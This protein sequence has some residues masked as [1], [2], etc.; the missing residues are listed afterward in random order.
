MF[1]GQ[2]RSALAA[3]AA[4]ALA[5]LA[6]AA[7]AD[8]APDV[9]LGNDVLPTFQSVRLHLDADRKDY[10]GAI[11]ADL[12]VV[13]AT[14]VVRLHALGQ[15]LQRVSLRQGADTV[16][17]TIE[18]G[19]R[20]LLTLT[21]ATPLAPGQASL[22]IEFTADFGTRAVGLYRVTQGGRGYAFTQ[23]ESDDAR[24]AF[25]CWD[26][27]C[28]K[29]PYQ[30]TLEVPEAHEAIS[31]TPVASQS[32][33]AGWKTVMFEKTPPLPSYLLAVAT[34][35]LEFVP[36]PGM[37]FPTR[38]VTVRGQGH[39]AGTTVA[40]VPRIVAG[41]EKWFGMPYP[42]AK[43]DLIAVPD[44]AYGAMENPGAITFRDDGLLLD[45]AT[46][47]ASCTR[48]ASETAPSAREHDRAC[49][50]QLHRVGA[51]DGHD[52]SLDLGAVE[53][54]GRRRRVEALAAEAHP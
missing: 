19:E 20:G 44:F 11:H 1:R 49:R 37:R 48:P 6:P 9:R 39:L 13:H 28:F 27:P 16:H 32:V 29:F 43:L 40:M 35:P 54:A 21:S 23:F 52:R 2:V 53:L 17:V 5:V 33:S 47:T 22:E 14:N 36:V 15:S 12:K 34:G 38:V 45:P 25:P 46:S 26:E 31:N 24:E 42:F 10:R 30:L 7:R 41:L 51:E 4:L 18:R 50:R 3:F 8:D